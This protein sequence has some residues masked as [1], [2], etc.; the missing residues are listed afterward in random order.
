MKNFLYIYLFLLCP[1]IV[2]AQVPGYQGK[3][4]SMDGDA[5]FMS[6]LFNPNENLKKGMTSFNARYHV[7]ADYVLTKDISFGATY[8]MFKTGWTP[9]YGGYDAGN[10]TIK[11]YFKVNSDIAGIYFKFFRSNKGAIAPSGAYQKLGA[12]LIMAKP[13][14]HH[15]SDSLIDDIK[16]PATSYK[17]IML[18]YGFGKQTIFYNRLVLRYGLE[19]GMSPDIFSLIFR[20]KRNNNPGHV[21]GL[22]LKERILSAYL[23]NI[24]VGLGIILF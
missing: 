14:F 6:A 8:G 20:D 18:T 22:N 1:A 3:R 2:S 16:T 21:I 9:S 15:S 24:N 4:F 5:F 11:D 10:T 12:S 7:N 13:S 23:V 19:F 17:M